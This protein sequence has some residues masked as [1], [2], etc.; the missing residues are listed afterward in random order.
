MVWKIFMYTC[1]V[2]AFVNEGCVFDT[3]ILH[4][5]SGNI[6]IIAMNYSYTSKYMH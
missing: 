6:F 2:L 5:V 3:V 1:M 4:L